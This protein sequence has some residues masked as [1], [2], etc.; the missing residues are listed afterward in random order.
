MLLRKL[1]HSRLLAE[2]AGTGILLV[3]FAPGPGPHAPSGQD[4]LQR[5]EVK[6]IL[7]GR[8]VPGHGNVFAGWICGLFAELGPAETTVLELDGSAPTEM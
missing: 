3:T 8:A 5:A 2:E 6:M 4:G 7:A 1:G